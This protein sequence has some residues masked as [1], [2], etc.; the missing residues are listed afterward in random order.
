MRSDSRQAH[1]RPG[2]AAVGRLVDAVADRRRVARPGLAGADPDV[3]PVRRVDR[4]RAD[5]LDRLLV[6]DGLEGRAAVDRLPHAA[7]G[8]A[9]EERRLAVDVVA[10]DGR[11][12][13]AHRRPS[14][15]CA[16]RGPRGRRCRTRATTTAAAGPRSWAVRCPPGRERGRA[17]PWSPAPETG[18]CASSTGTFT[19]TR[20]T[21]PVL[22]V[23]VA[24]C[25][26]ES[27]RERHP[28]ARDLLVVAVGRSR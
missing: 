11:D 10:G 4:D 19:S 3:L 12:A 22:V 18:R 14:R 9:D 21:A 15:C 13:P 8:G 26:P 5:R 7:R 28:D 17:R 2:L 24:P 27:D 20:S 16:R 6:E 1:V 23:P 25:R